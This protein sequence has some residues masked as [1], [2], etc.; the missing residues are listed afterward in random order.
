MNVHWD[1][2][3]ENNQHLIF[4]GC[5]RCHDGRHASADGRV[6]PHDC[7]DCHTILAQGHPGSME[8]AR[9]ADGLT[10]RHPVDIGESWRQV[11]C[12]VCHTGTGAG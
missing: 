5:F 1:V 8:Y 2:Y 9:S 7:K 11:G 12:H 4:T 6:V 10:F 3:P